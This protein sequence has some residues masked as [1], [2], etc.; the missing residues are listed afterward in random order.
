MKAFLALAA[1]AEHAFW[2]AE[3]ENSSAF[4][5]S[6]KRVHA[7]PELNGVFHRTSSGVTLLTAGQSPP[8]F[9]NSHARYSK[10][11]YHSQFG[12]SLPVYETRTEHGVHDSMLAFDDGSGS[13]RVRNS[14]KD[15]QVEGSGV[16]CSFEPCKGVIVQSLLLA[17]ESDWHFRL[18]R[19]KTE[20]SVL[21]TEQG[22]ALGRAP[23]HDQPF[24][25]RRESGSAVVRTPIGVSAI[26]GLSSQVSASIKLVA[27][28]GAVQEAQ[29]N[30]SIV[31]RRTVIPKLVVELEP[32]EHWLG[33]AVMAR[34]GDSE[35]AL[36]ALPEGFWPGS[37]LHHGVLPDLTR[38]LTA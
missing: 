9:V 32:G 13:W 29:P 25:F 30:S 12:F 19:V 17:T 38:F 2:Q 10:F 24:S 1:P 34:L 3:E 23:S 36:P 35:S 15:V 8:P 31:W 16:T 5:G 7:V 20:Q 14:S 28:R 27:R 4:E 26:V 21:C 37:A 11:A 33:C 18:H 22:F 6:L